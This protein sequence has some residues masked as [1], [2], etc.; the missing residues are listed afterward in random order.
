MLRPRLGKRAASDRPHLQRK[1]YRDDLGKARV[2]ANRIC[3][4]SLW[5]HY[6]ESLG[7]GAVPIDGVGAIPL[8]PCDDVTSHLKAI[9]VRLLAPT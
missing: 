7:L 3:R 6:F 8:Q 1:W 4:G 9:V 2:V 5:Q